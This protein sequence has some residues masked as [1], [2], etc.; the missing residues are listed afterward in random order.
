MTLTTRITLIGLA[1]A[2]LLAW[3]LGG[4]R[5]AGTIAGY[6]AGASIT[7]FAL[8]RQ[9]HVFRTAPQRSLHTMV[10]GFLLKLAGIVLAV[11]VLATVPGARERVDLLSFCLAFAVAALLALF[12]GTWSNARVLRERAE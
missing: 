6:L 5:G 4:A 9:R 1:A 10:E 8:A 12:P 11:I 2:M 3:R 7:G